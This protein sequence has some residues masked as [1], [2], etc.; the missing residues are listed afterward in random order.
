MAIVYETN[1]PQ[2]KEVEF[3]IYTW[4]TQNKRW[5]LSCDVFKDSYYGYVAGK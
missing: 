1:N 5:T 4:G 2:K 3:L